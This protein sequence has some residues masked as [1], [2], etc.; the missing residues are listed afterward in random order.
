[1]TKRKERGGCY[2]LLFGALGFWIVDRLAEDAVAPMFY[3]EAVHQMVA[4]E[5]GRNTLLGTLFDPVGIGRRG[6]DILGVGPA[7][8]LRFDIT[9]TNPGT[10]A[11]HLARPYG[12]NL[13]LITYERPP[14]FT[15]FP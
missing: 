4:R 13:I 1:M 15:V 6:P 12:Q 14:G 3:G 7:A 8:G 9:T 2:G 5:I 11:E 10:M